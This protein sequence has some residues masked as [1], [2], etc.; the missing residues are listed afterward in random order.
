HIAP[1]VLVV[2]AGEID[3]AVACRNVKGVRN[4]V[5]EPL[6]RHVRVEQHFIVW[7]S[8][9]WFG[10]RPLRPIDNEARSL[11]I[12]SR[13]GRTRSGAAPDLNLRKEFTV[14]NL[15]RGHQVSTANCDFDRLAL[16]E[17]RPRGR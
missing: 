3:V 4:H 9:A 7:Q 17:H 2:S 15:N 16:C 8:F 10:G 5:Y 14:S 11:W 6:L 1:V 12:K 13:W